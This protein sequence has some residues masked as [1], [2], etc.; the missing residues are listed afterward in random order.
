[1]RASGNAKKHKPE[2]KPPRIVVYTSS[3]CHWCRV[4]KA[5]LKDHDLPY[6][7]VDIISDKRGRRE[8]VAMTGQHGVPVIKVGHR[9]MV[10][11]DKKEFQALLRGDGGR[12]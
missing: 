12:R 5:Y 1:M 3:T 11:W 2:G 9:A 10:G 4:A 6:T 7:E 8:M